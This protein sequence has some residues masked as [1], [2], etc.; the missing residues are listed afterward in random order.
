MSLY[1]TEDV[2]PNLG[3]FY[4]TAYEDGYIVAVPSA[5]TMV[6]WKTA[7]P[8]DACKLLC[9]LHGKPE[10]GGLV[11]TKTRRYDEFYCMSSS[12]YGSIHWVRIEDF[13]AARLEGKIEV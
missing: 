12:R 7:Y 9:P 11:E 2:A 3:D 5:T 8:S 4:M 10:C 13:V 6:V 1:E